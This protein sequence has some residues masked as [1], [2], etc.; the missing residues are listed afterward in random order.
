MRESFLRYALG[1]GDFPVNRFSGLNCGLETLL[2][3]DELVVPGIPQHKMRYVGPIGP[4]GEDV[5]DPAKGQRAR[6]VY[7]DLLPNPDQLVLGERGTTDW[8]EALQ[9]QARAR[10]VVRL[11]VVNRWL[12]QN[13]E[14]IGFYI[15]H[16]KP[17]SPQLRF[18][19]GVAAAAALIF[20]FSD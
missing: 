3:G 4:N 15:R 18:W 10:E 13:C 16:G 19:G 9:I 8:N 1:S 7:Y 17:K 6:F 20:L 5:V 14:H 12:D 2:V 11:R